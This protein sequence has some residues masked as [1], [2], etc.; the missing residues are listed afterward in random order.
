LNLSRY[1]AREG[2]IAAKMK[3]L[4]SN[5]LKERSRAMTKVFRDIALEN[6]REWIGKK[7]KIIIDEKGTLEGSWIGRNECY[8]PV[9]V[10]GDYKLG[11]EFDVEIFDATKFDLR[12]QVH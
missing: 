10:K 6:N 12:G 7:C 5:I 1:A 8:R 2:T 4:Q 9:I 11:D 3:Q